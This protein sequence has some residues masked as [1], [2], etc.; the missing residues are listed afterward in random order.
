MWE[1]HTVL[2][3]R[4]SY[5][6][7][8]P[9]GDTYPS[10]GADLYVF[11]AEWKLLETF[12]PRSGPVPYQLECAIRLPYDKFRVL[13]GPSDGGNNQNGSI[14]ELPAD[15][16]KPISIPPVRDVGGSLLGFAAPFAKRL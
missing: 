9:G 6:R 13:A 7:M 10:P 1:L 8:S 14:V 3:V 16:T 4:T 2:P 11:D 15:G 5:A 12:S